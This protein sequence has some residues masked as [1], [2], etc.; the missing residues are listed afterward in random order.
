[1]KYEEALKYITGKNKFGEK[2]GLEGIKRLCDRLS[3]PEKNLRCVHVAG[4]NGKGS[5]SVYI[6]TALQKAGYKTGLYTSPF[7]YE[8]NERIKINNENI[9]DNELAEIM[10]EVKNVVD[11]LVSEGYPQPTEF[12]IIT[13]MAFL[14]YNRKK[15]DIVVL[16]VGLGGRFDSTNIIESPLV[17]VICSIGYDHTQFLG[18]TIDKIAFEKCGIIKD[19][20]PVV[21]YPL[22]VPDAEKTVRKISEEKNSKLITCNKEN[23]TIKKMALKGSV[24]DAC[25]IENIETA[26]CGEHQ[27]YN[28]TVSIMVLKELRKQGFDITDDVIKEGIKSAKWPARMETLKNEPLLIFDGAHNVDGMECF[29]K[30]VSQLAEDKKKIIV[31]GM[32]KDKEYSKCIKLLDGVVDV[33]ITTT[34][35]NPRRETAENLMKEAVNLSCEKHITQNI[36]EAVDKALELYDTNSVI[37]AVGSLYMANEIKMKIEKIKD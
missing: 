25:G 6:A 36:S 35:E 22:L 27:I 9:S 31:L 16:E 1:M 7:I 19:G 8:F 5:T 2:H 34:L 37:F 29:V 28:A 10:T 18:D 24:F 23:I 15:C 12:E 30:N 26:L 14:Y 17:S 11:A 32:V 13:A 20:R 21:C 4:T 3:N 33:L